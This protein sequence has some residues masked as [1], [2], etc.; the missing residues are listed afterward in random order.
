MRWMLISIRTA[1]RAGRLSS[2]RHNSTATLLKDDLPSSSSPSPELEDPVPASEEKLEPNAG[3]PTFESLRDAVSPRTLKALIGEPFRLK[4]MS[5]V[6][7][8]V[9]PLLPDL[10]KLTAPGEELKGP[11]DLMVK[12]RTGTGK[13]LAFL[14]PAV[15]S[16]LNALRAHAEQVARDTENNSKTVLMRA[17]NKYA[18]QNVGAL[19]ISPTR[20]LATQIANE[21]IKLT[22]H[23]DMF[24][25][26]LFVGG[27]PKRKQ[28]REWNLGRRDIIVATP[29]RL[30]DFIETEPGFKEELQTT[31]TVSIMVQACQP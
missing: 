16:R 23:H 21:A 15:E 18:K 22:Q 20:E 28:Q 13:T 26:R 24:E 27:L 31:E 3:Q 9:L 11:R 30:L 2:V 6:Q 25:V 29:G 7:A 10:V 19:I 4:Y 12:A 1:L 8:E 17:V 14:I 5:P